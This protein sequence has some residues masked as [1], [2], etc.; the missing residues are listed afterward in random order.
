MLQPAGSDYFPMARV[1][2]RYPLG[3]PW[4]AL[5]PVDSRWLPYAAV[6]FH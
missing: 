4:L 3:P 1:E 2:A 5:A 6:G